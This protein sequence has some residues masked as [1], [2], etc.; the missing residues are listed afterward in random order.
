M[1][2]PTGIL[3]QA[4]N[5][6]VRDNSNQLIKKLQPQKTDNPEVNHK[7]RKVSSVPDRKYLP[8]PKA[9]LKSLKALS[10]YSL[11]KSS[12]QP[13]LRQNS[14][15][16]ANIAKGIRHETYRTENNVLHGVP[17]I[18]QG[19]P[20]GCL[21]ACHGMLLQYFDCKDAHQI[22]GS[23]HNGVFVQSDTHRSMLKGVD[24]EDFSHSLHENGLEQTALSQPDT[25]SLK[26]H[27]EKGPL[28]AT[29]KFAKG[30]TTHSILVVGKVGNNVILNDPWH[31]GHQVKSMAWLEKNLTKDPNALCLISRADND[32]ANI[33]EAP[34]ATTGKLSKLL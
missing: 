7:G 12:A 21:D 24:S 19:S 4:L 11:K 30:L 32:S 17:H 1:K 31:G 16:L 14:S 23:H 33:P 3:G 9:L 5:Y 22:Q 13:L 18:Q 10:A 29:I 2:L 20:N 34:P 15:P 27:I 25:A 8:S 6:K 28:L 26:K